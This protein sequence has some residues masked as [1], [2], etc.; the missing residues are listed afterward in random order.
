MFKNIKKKKKIKIQNNKNSRYIP[1]LLLL[2]HL[3]FK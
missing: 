3:K 1:L 2:Y